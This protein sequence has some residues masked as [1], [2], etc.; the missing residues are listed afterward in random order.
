M[1]KAK[2]VYICQSCEFQSIRWVGQCPRCLQWDT[3]VE[4]V[5]DAK[6]AGSSQKTPQSFPINLKEVKA[7]DSKRFSTGMTE[8]DRVLGGGIAPGQVILLAGDPGIGKSTLITQLAQKLHDKNILYICGEESPQQIKI[9]TERMNYKGE[10]LYL[11]A[12]TDVDAV[13]STISSPVGLTVVDSIQSVT[14][15][16]LTSS[17][18]S[19]GQVRECAQRLT[20]IAKQKSI[21]VILIGHVTKEGTVAGPKVLEHIVDTVLYL[22]GDSQHMHRVLKTAK[23]RF[24]PVSEVGLFEM[25][26]S[27]MKDVENPSELFLSRQETPA[28]GTCVAVVMEGFRPLLFEIQALTTRTAFGY[29]SRITS[30][31]SSGRLKVLIAILEKRCGFDLSNHDV[32]V[33][34]AGGYRID[35]YGADLAVCLAIAS[36]LKDKPLTAKVA[37]FGECGLSGEIRQVTYHKKREAEAKKLGY[38]NVISFEKVRYLKAAVSLSLG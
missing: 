34:V 5:V 35:E 33:N 26:E 32:F 20:N 28:S 36:S 16:D 22:E 9:R 21:P 12:E 8:L 18:G 24:G 37:A 27:G 25:S 29:P 10:N 38:K 7:E 11:L 15:T 31:F 2:T 23:N 6:R 30:G 17:A 19:V 4:T 14:T 3:F 13:V 1:P